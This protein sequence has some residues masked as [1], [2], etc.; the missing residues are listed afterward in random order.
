[1]MILSD[2]SLKINGCTMGQDSTKGLY[3]Y[4]NK[5]YNFDFLNINFI[6]ILISR[7]VQTDEKTSKSYL[8]C[9]FRHLEHAEI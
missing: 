2:F 3:D 4:C 1:M 5:M 9:E 7:G 8:K 6:V